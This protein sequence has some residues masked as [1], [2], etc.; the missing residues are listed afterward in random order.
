MATIAGTSATNNRPNFNAGVAGVIPSAAS[1]TFGSI[2]NASPY[3]TGST[4]GA[5]Y[6]NLGDRST[7]AEMA[8]IDPITGQGYFTPVDPEVE[9]ALKDAVARGI[10]GFDVDEVTDQKYIS[11]DEMRL[12]PEAPWRQNN[13]VALSIEQFTSYAEPKTTFLSPAQDPAV[14]GGITQAKLVINQLN[15]VLF[16][17]GSTSSKINPALEGPLAKAVAENVTKVAARLNYSKFSSDLEKILN[18]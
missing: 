10:P 1:Q 8:M 14:A 15:D 5:S 4:G 18:S 12:T 6:A 9:A 17:S 16:N 3:A 7:W 11:A 13:Q 2:L